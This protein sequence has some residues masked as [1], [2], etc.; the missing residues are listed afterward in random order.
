MS[1]DGPIS[2]EKL[3]RMVEENELQHSDDTFVQV[4]VAVFFSAFTCF[5]IG[6]LIISILAAGVT[7]ITGVWFLSVN[8]MIVCGLAQWAIIFIIIMDNLKKRIKL[9]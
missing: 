4:A 1:N 7:E 9:D 2:D 6:V 8:G 5:P 3:A